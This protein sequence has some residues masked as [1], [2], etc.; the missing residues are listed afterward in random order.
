MVVGGELGFEN[1]PIAHSQRNKHQLHLQ[2][3]RDAPRWGVCFIYN[4]PTT[5]R[6]NQVIGSLFS[7]YLF[8]W[9]PSTTYGWQLACC[10]SV[11]WSKYGDH[12]NV[13]TQSGQIEYDSGAGW[14]AAGT[15]MMQ[16]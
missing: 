13:M 4:C 12:E 7:G 14:Q 15:R 9:M 6:G 8:R 10:F 5:V 11:V 2:Q 3:I 16:T 1:M